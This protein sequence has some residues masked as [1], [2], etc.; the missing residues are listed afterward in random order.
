MIPSTY[1][2]FIPKHWKTLQ[3]GTQ[4][5]LVNTD[6]S[7]LKYIIKSKFIKEEDGTP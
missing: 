7:M 3:K 1:N 5:K 4:A 6:A 2:G